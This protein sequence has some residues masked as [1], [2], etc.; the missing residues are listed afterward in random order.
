MPGPAMTSARTA[1]RGPR[2]PE[3][4]L[5]EPFVR[6]VGADLTV[7]LLLTFGGA[8]LYFAKNASVRSSVAKVVGPDGVRA[9]EQQVSAGMLR[10]PLAN[11]WIANYLH[12]REVP[13]Q[14]IA[15]RLRTSDVT[16]R[17]YL[18]PHRALSPRDSAQLKLL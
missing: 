2:R 17:K 1:K 18:K 4:E 7:E 9:L 16:V 13:I 11:G 14:E 8:E 3:A 12:E 15:R 10:V 6:A 5:V